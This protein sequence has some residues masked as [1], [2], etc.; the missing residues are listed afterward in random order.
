MTSLPSLPAHPIRVSAR[1]VI[2]ARDSVLL[3]KFDDEHGPHYNWP[4]G[5][6]DFGET[7]QQ[8]VMREVWEETHA[9]VEVGELLCVYEHLRN[10]D[11]IQI[12]MP[13]SLSLIFHCT[14]VDGSQP[15]LPDTPDEN[16]IAV[17]WIPIDELGQ[18]WVLPNIV[19]EVQAWWKGNQNGIS[20]VVNR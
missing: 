10:D 19:P 17:E 5:G 20:F 12:G 11:E 3:A 6:M 15:C 2:T 16:Q 9:K 13:Q 8:A 1:A 18:H 14:L 7:V 4:G